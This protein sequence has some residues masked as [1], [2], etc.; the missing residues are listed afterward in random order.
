MTK[1]AD[2]AALK[3]F[4]PPRRVIIPAP[5]YQVLTRRGEIDHER[6]EKA[7]ASIEAL[8]M[9]PTLMGGAFEQTA[10]FAGTDE[11][12]ARDFET[13]LLSEDA[14]LVMPLR[15]GYGMTRLLYLLDWKKIASA[16][17]PVVGFSDFTAFNLALLAMT[18]RYSW[19]GPML[20]SFA[21]PDPFMVE[22]FRVVFG[23]NPGSLAWEAEPA[24]LGEMKKRFQR[25]GTLWGGNLC[26]IESLLGTRWFP[27]EET[28]SG[29]LF[30]ED[31]GEAAYRVERMLLSLL[32]SGVLHRQ[33][34]I[35]F[36]AFTN[37]DDAVRFEGDQT[38]ARTLGYIRSRLPS[39]IP[40]VTGLPFGHIDRK[41]TLP[42]GLPATISLDGRR[43]RLSWRM[44]S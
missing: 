20:M 40:M 22:R 14:D 15:G 44:P 9:I 25:T 3:P 16:R 29:I 5:S 10:R 8:G 27:F 24:L 43:A 32:E 4:E 17:V 13:A 36:G 39:C 6:R 41:A 19:Q 18:G 35:L 28:G 31:V 38:L 33:R 11:V 23:E 30:L 26:L 7:I 42:V 12:R 21:D 1:K 34:A 37:A 2:S